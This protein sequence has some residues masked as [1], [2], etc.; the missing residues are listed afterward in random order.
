MNWLETLSIV[1]IITGSSVFEVSRSM[2]L[3]QIT[4]YLRAAPAVM[5][6]L[7][8]NVVEKKKDTMTDPKQIRA[9]I[10]TSKIPRKA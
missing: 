4:R 7:T 5:P 1:A 10:A 2:T 6:F 9:W 3:G 8:G